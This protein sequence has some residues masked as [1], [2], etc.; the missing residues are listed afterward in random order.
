MARKVAPPIGQV[1]PIVD[2][3]AIQLR[4][5]PGAGGPYEHKFVDRTCTVCGYSQSAGDSGC[6]WNVGTMY[7]KVPVGRRVR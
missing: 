1:W 2:N 5:A 6:P 4:A 3:A 7:E